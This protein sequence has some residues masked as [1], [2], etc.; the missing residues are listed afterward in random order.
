MGA[1]PG[2]EPSS[3]PSTPTADD[4]AATV[5]TSQTQ[6]IKK[7]ANKLDKDPV[8]IYE[9]VRNNIIYEPYFGSRKGAQETLWEKGGNDIDQAN[10]M[11]AL[12]RYSNIPAR[13]VTGV[14]EI[15]IDRAMNWVGVEKEEVAAKVF[16][17][18]GIPSKA[19]VRGGKIDAIEM[20]HTWAE[21][22]VPYESYRGVD[23]GS[24]EKT[25]VAL[26]VSYKEMEYR[27]AMDVKAI[28]GIDTTSFMTTDT[29]VLLQKINEATSAL[30]TYIT[31]NMTDATLGDV[32]GAKEIIK[33]ELGL[34]PSSLPEGIKTISVDKEQDQLTDVQRYKL[35]LKTN[36]LDYSASLPELAGKR[37]TLY[38]SPATQRDAD[39]VV[40]YGSLFSVPAYMIKVKPIV[41]VDDQAV[42]SGS[43]LTLGEFQD[44]S[45]KMTSSAR[46]DSVTKTLSAGAYY[47]IGLDYGKVSPESLRSRKDKLSQTMAA[48]DSDNSTVSGDEIT[49]ELLNLTSQIYFSQVDSFSNILANQTKV[50]TFKEPS[51]AV[52]SY[53][54]ETSYVFGTP[55]DVKSSG[56]NFDLISNAHIVQPKDGDQAKAKAWTVAAGYLSSGGEH[57][58]F[59]QMY[60][61]QA[62]ST[63]KIFALANDQ[64]IAIRQITK[65]NIST[66]LPQIETSQEIK[67]E[68]QNSV[69]QGRVVTIPET[70]IT[71]H[72][73]TGTGWVDMDPNTG[74][75]GYM[76]QGGLAG[77]AICQPETDSNQLWKMSHD[78][79][80]TVSDLAGTSIDEAKFVANGVLQTRWR[81]KI[82]GRFMSAKWTSAIESISLVIMPALAALDQWLNDLSNPDL[83]SW[84][85]VDRALW[86]FN[87]ALFVALIAAVFIVPLVVS[88]GAPALAAVVIAAAIS[89]ILL[90]VW[91]RISE[92]VFEG[93]NLSLIPRREGDVYAV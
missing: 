52:P 25:W 18:A 11:I 82:N 20:E 92:Q 64:N 27:E 39:L 2:L 90:L 69:N 86:T 30:E 49:G 37:I 78:L 44:L 71:Y 65:E 43:H 22:Y 53:T 80:G 63:V 45:I 75:A 31:E 79:L 7:L 1:T 55:S 88:L 41:L 40:E 4:L 72:S 85:R 21:V 47:A 83:E 57:S 34:L 89:Y 61:A 58:V 91:E 10:L 56:A 13:Y 87:M 84:Q 36:G 32:I 24:G 46:Q 81:N 29:A 19:I 93:W 66:E 62:V 26:D 51:V 3:L 28:A 48:L 17:A 8:K 73:W 70:P 16:S 42:S 68:I 15:P 12:F 9:F 35:S 5:D 77:G 54:I 67:N 74:A 38:Y 76:I 6:A 59:E 33:E 50:V 14:V 60:Q 23:T